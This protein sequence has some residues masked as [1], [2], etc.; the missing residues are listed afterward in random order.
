MKDNGFVML[1]SL[2]LPSY[3]DIVKVIIITML[4]ILKIKLRIFDQANFFVAKVATVHLK[5]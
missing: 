4:F 5:N 2:N 3:L 1:D